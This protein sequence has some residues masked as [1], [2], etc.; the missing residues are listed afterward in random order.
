MPLPKHLPFS[1][2]TRTV[3]TLLARTWVTGYHA[4]Y[5][6][7]VQLF[8]DRRYSTPGADLMGPRTRRTRW[9]WLKEPSVTRQESPH[10]V[11]SQLHSLTHAAKNDLI[12]PELLPRFRS[13]TGL[14][15][16]TWRVYYHRRPTGRMQ[17]AADLLSKAQG[18]VVFMHGWDGSHAIWE[19]L[20]AQVCQA[21]PHLVCLAL[22]VNGF[23]GSPFIEANMPALEI[24]GPRAA[25]R[26]VE[27]WLDLLRLHRPGRQRQVFTFVGH[28][29]SGAALFHK[30]T[31]GWE[32]DSYS[33]LLLAPAMLHKDTVKQAL[34]RTLGVG[35]GVGW[36]YEFLDRFKQLLVLQAMDL[37]A[38]GASRVVKKEHDRI[39]RDT[40]KGTIAQTFFALGLAEETP[41]ERPWDNVFVMLAHRDRLVGLGPTLDLLEEM[42][43][44]SQHIQVVL[45]DHYFFSVG[46]SSRRLH[47]LNRAEVLRHILRLHDERR[48]GG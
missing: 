4:W 19:G 37:L 30:A 18:Y 32:D 21:N 29:M 24:C 28:S 31:R 48:A 23:G 13:A 3:S 25:M 39:F 9:D 27:L 11:M 45:G 46:Q 7:M 6:E 26:A 43:L 2:G 12:S 41:P 14:A 8:A 22:D 40:P 47:A 1:P 33:L 5:P 35:I 44:T 34:Y 42:G 36:Q 17:P 15:D 20:P 38:A 10:W 16:F